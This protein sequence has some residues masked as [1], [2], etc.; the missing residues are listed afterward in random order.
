[1]AILTA[2]PSIYPTGLLDEFTPETP[3]RRWW[4]LYTKSRQEKA[5]ARRLLAWEI[6]FYLPVVGK[7][8]YSRGRTTFSRMPMFAGYVFLYATEEQRV[9]V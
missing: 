1:M 4:V 3:D 6:P 5:V 8:N 7:T 9:H 2:E